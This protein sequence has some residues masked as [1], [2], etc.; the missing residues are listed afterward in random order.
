MEDSYESLDILVKEDN[1]TR[2]LLLTHIHPINYINIFTKWLGTSLT[3]LFNKLITVSETASFFAAL[4]Y[5]LG[6]NN[7]ERNLRK[8][9][10]MYLTSATHTND[11]LSMY[12]VFEIHFNES[13]TFRVK[14]D[15]VLEMFFLFKSCAYLPC[16]TCDSEIFREFNPK[17]TLFKYI[18][19]D[20][21]SFKKFGLFLDVIENNIS[22]NHLL[23]D[24]PLINMTVLY[25]TEHLED[26]NVFKQLLMNNNNINNGEMLLKLASVVYAKNKNYSFELLEECVRMNYYRAYVKYGMFLQID[27]A[28]LPEA[29]E[30]YKKGFEGGNMLCYSYYYYLNLR[31]VDYTSHESVIKGLSDNLSYLINAIVFKNYALICEYLDVVKYI[32]KRKG[33]LPHEHETYLKEIITFI[34]NNKHTNDYELLCCLGTLYSFKYTNDD[35]KLQHSLTEA[36]NCFNKLSQQQGLP[37][38]SQRA[39]HER[40]FNIKKK[41][42]KQSLI[43]QDEMIT[44]AKGFLRLIEACLVSEEHI[45]QNPSMHYC[46]GMLMEFI[47]GKENNNERHLQKAYHHYH[48]SASY[49]SNYNFGFRCF[50]RKQ[51]SINKIN[52]DKFIIIKE[53]MIIDSEE[54]ITPKPLSVSLVECEICFDNKLNVYFVPCSH[55]CCAICYE[56]LKG[57]K[58]P[59]CRR[60]I[61]RII[62]F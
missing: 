50:I 48:K 47:H 37:I 8:A 11:Y 35:D 44:T 60:E 5:E 34:L 26:V 42:Y 14:R 12:R 9:Y 17:H 33:T 41:L 13:Q 51:K 3:S 24:V 25:L 36:L 18:E 27:L 45:K 55:K 52:E 31:N 30:I 32:L 10:K 40:I 7:K 1:K 49:I 59:F 58:C 15:K 4:E 6:L 23:K 54:T 56:K 21:P 16:V 28:M 46:I 29:L 20:D 57:M 39:I 53:G 61:T 19:L 2:Q 22:Y 62:H 43:T 38:T